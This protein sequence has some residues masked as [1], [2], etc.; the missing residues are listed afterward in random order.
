MHQAP[1]IATIT[2]PVEGVLHYSP[3]RAS[4]STCSIFDECAW[5]AEDCWRRCQM[6]EDLGP[7]ASRSRG[8]QVRH[9]SPRPLLG[10][11]TPR[12]ESWL[13]VAQSKRRAAVF[14]P[15]AAL[16]KPLAQSSGLCLAL[17]NESSLHLVPS[18]FSQSAPC[19]AHC[20]LPNCHQCHA[21]RLLTV[22]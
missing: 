14:A 15:L 20:I 9:S 1:D 13:Q 4:D 8:E 3:P 10:V 2:A 19:L 16:A 21:S 17:S 7:H 5:H 22:H 18:A 6:G 11:A 12:G